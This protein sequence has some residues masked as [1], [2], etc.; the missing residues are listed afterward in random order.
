[1]S[2]LIRVSDSAYSKLDKIV[3]NTG[4]SRQEVI[5][6]A[7][8]NLEREMI[9]QQANEAYAMLRKDKKLWQEEQEE[10]ALWDATLSDGL[11]DE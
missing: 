1:M 5:D 8:A 9:L 11:K 4:F 10:M 6:R 7:V 3:E 2:R